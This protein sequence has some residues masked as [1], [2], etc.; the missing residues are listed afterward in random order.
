M[1]RF[2]AFFIICLAFSSFAFTQAR[3]APSQSASQTGVPSGQ[4]D[5]VQNA[6][7]EVTAN[8]PHVNAAGPITLAVDATRAAM[9]ILHAHLTI[10]VSGGGEVTLVYPKWIPGEH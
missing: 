5:S 10:P 9:K 7:R 4:P 2:L 8:A 6:T 1:Q 3:M